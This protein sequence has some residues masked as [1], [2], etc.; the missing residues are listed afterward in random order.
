M[1]INCST[2][3]VLLC[4]SLFRYKQGYVHVN[5][6]NAIISHGKSTSKS[7][8]TYELFHNNRK[9][10]FQHLSNVQ[11]TSTCWQKKHQKSMKTKKRT[12]GHH[13][14]IKT[15]RDKSM[16]TSNPYLVFHCFTSSLENLSESIVIVDAVANA[17]FAAPLGAIDEFVFPSVVVGGLWLA[18]LARRLS[19]LLF[20]SYGIWARLWI[21]I[22]QTM[23][24][25]SSA[26]IRTVERNSK[27]RN[28]EHWICRSRY[29]TFQ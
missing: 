3:S 17:T 6:F 21:T 14:K 22:S 8:N 28:T 27:T 7:K 18:S 16:K 25:S 1:H 9:H 4:I 15:T 13:K 2:T 29:V 24:K 11:T 20:W 26:I 10:E 12:L 19:A 5:H 23:S